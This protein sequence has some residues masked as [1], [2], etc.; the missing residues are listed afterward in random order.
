MRRVSNGGPP[1]GPLTVI[2]GVALTAGRPHPAEVAWTPSVPLWTSLS[3]SG[4]IINAGPGPTWGSPP[5][6]ARLGPLP[7]LPEPVAAAPPRPREL[8][9]LFADT[10]NPMLPP[11]TPA[12]RLVMTTPSVPLIPAHPDVVSP[13][14]AAQ[15]AQPRPIR[16]VSN[17]SPAGSRFIPVRAV[18]AGSATPAA[19][20]AAPAR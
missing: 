18:E 14:L 15:A 11:G 2:L 4:K 17:A 10:A 5:P 6:A 7:Q 3:P 13:P 1:V 20:L 12:S 16:S 19:R 9:H 8:P